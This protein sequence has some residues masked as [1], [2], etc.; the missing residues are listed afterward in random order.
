[1][2]VKVGN[3]RTYK[4]NDGSVGIRVDRSSI[5]GNPFHMYHGED[6][7]DR[8][9]DQYDNYFDMRMSSKEDTVFKQEV[10]RI[11]NYARYRD[12][13]LL[14]WCYPQRCHAETI[15]KYI[16]TK[17]EEMKDEPIEVSREV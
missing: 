15:K 5:L 7:R 4:G 16:E 11:L 10:Q 8:V 13:T 12:V 17:L 9:C 1:M 6:D 2:A 3:I 14:C